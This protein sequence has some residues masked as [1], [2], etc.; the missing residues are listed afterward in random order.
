MALAICWHSAACFKNW[1]AGSIEL[2]GRSLLGFAVPLPGPYRWSTNS[3]NRL[4]IPSSEPRPHAEGWIVPAEVRSVDNPPPLRSRVA[5]LIAKIAIAATFL[6]ALSL[7]A[8]TEGMSP[9]RVM[10]TRARR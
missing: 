6:A 10:P 3:S 1:S 8:A 2:I 9:L 7:P 4:L 5:Y